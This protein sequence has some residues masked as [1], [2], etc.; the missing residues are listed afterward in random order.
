MVNY[1]CMSGFQLCNSPST[2]LQTSVIESVWWNNNMHVD[3]NPKLL[4]TN[5]KGVV[6]EIN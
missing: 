1:V 3:M 4:G 5:F 6:Y 2:Y